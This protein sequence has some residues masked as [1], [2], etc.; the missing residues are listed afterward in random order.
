MNAWN[1]NLYLLRENLLFFTVSTF[2]IG[3]ISWGWKNA[4]PYTV[5]LPFPWWY[6]WWFLTMQIL[7]VLLPL[8][9]MLLWGVWWKQGIVLAVLDWYFIILVWQIFFETFTLRKLQHVVWVMVPYIY[10]PYRFWQLYEG[11]TLLGSQTE[12]LWV[13]YLLILELVLWIVNYAI[14]VVQLPR[15]FRW[16]VNSAP[17][18]SDN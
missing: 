1:I 5:P 2:L 13:R 16:E 18:I 6:K 14:D 11:L 7:G 10:L 12:L 3:V 17:V 4:K 8:L 9:I 15:L